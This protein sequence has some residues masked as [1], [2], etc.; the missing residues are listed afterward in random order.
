MENL[1]FSERIRNGEDLCFKDR[2]S[3]VYHLSLPGILAQISEIVM[4]KWW[5]F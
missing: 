2:L 1:D 3:V 4:R 5:V